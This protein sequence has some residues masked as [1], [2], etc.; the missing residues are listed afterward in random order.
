MPKAIMS[1]LG[2]IIVFTLL[3]SVVSLIG[4]VI[5]LSKE[6]LAR[7]IS[8][9]LSSFAAGVLLATAFVDLLPEALEH[10]EELG[11]EVNI[12]IWVLLGILAFFLLERFIH[13][14]H[15]HHDHKEV[16]NEE[17][18]AVIPLIVL[19][20]T[21]HNFIDGVVIAATFMVDI[22]LGML[23]TFA[24]AAHEIP[25][26]IG[27]FGI[28]IH[29]GMKKLSILLVNIVSALGALTGAV[30]TYL[31]GGGLDNI[32]PI[33]LSIAAGFFIYIALSDL[34]PEI[35]GED[36]RDVAFWETVLLILGVVVI[37]LAV[38]YLEQLI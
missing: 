33:F 2:Y 10:A 28:M 16:P 38:T 34:I 17:K 24:V 9:F 26:E 27:D 20:D 35:H 7:K 15:H 22:K 8:H 12:F 32:L 18:K 1:T 14:F 5:L 30:L 4:G 19:G 13:W 6:K 25:Q 31:V 29:R 36:R 23:T 21:V 37:W 11:T 3:G